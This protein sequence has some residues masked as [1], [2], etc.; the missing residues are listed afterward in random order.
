MSGGSINP[1]ELTA[2]LINSQKSIP[3]GIRYAQSRI[4]GSMSMLLLTP[5]GLYAARERM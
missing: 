2:A 4:D 3:E 5:D 1:T